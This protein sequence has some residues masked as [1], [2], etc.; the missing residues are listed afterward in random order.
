MSFTQ[1]CKCIEVNFRRAVLPANNPLLI[2]AI[3]PLVWASPITQPTK[4][5]FI[6][7]NFLVKIF[8]IK[9]DKKQRKMNATW[10]GNAHRLICYLLY[11]LN[12]CCSEFTF[13]CIPFTSVHSSNLNFQSITHYHPATTHGPKLQK[14]SEEAY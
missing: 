8:R 7:I 4:P 1:H 5:N 14:S 2:N 9:N 6:N 12:N 10:T 13:F 11:I 3:F